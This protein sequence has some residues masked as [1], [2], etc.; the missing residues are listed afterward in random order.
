LTE[1]EADERWDEELDNYIDECIM[2]EIPD[3][4][5]NYFDEKAWKHDARMDGRG[6]AISR[7]DGDENEYKIEFDDDSE[8]WINIY[9]M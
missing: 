7:Y 9:R 3:C 1:D 4:Y 6:H 8:C 5:Q 2:P